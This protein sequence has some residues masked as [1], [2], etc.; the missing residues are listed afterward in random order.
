MPEASSDALLSTVEITLS[1]GEI[2]EAQEDAVVCP[3]NSRLIMGGGLARSLVR[4]GGREIEEE[5]IRRGPAALGSCVVTGA[6]S[7][8]FRHVLHAVITTMNFR[9]DA[10]KVRSA[11]ADAL[12]CVDELGLR[13]VAFPPLGTELAGIT[14]ALSADVMLHAFRRYAMARG[15]DAG[16]MRLRVVLSDEQSY[17]VFVSALT[18]I[19]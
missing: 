17:Q 18:A 14:P 4:R 2:L 19:S 12:K 5:A 1:L 11:T 9:S 15:D 10:D 3:A 16:P 7:L 13:S 6:G 8:A